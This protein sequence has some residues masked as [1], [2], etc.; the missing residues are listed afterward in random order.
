MKRFFVDIQ[1]KN[2]NTAHITGEEAIHIHR[3]LRL[4]KGDRVIVCFGD[5]YDYPCE[6][7]E[8]SNK[9]VLVKLMQPTKNQNENKA[10]LTLYASLIKADKE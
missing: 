3:V 7:L 8:S 1:N 4:N 6:I 5:G 2:G 9:N 10:H